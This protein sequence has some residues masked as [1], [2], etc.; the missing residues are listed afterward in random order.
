MKPATL[1]ALAS[2]QSWYNFVPMP[3]PIFVPKCDSKWS[4]KR[5]QTG[6]LSTSHPGL[7]VRKAVPRHV[8]GDGDVCV[9][10]SDSE[11][12]HH[13]QYLASSAKEGRDRTTSAR[14]LNGKSFTSACIPSK[15]ELCMDM[16]RRPA[17]IEPL[18]RS[19]KVIGAG[20]MAALHPQECMPFGGR[21]N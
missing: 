3:G 13:D 7:G 14:A 6:P 20:E 19:D 8:G 5:E 4:R 2:N 18:P 15:C 11:H 10:A 12:E 9:C 17:G 21:H 16:V 1:Q